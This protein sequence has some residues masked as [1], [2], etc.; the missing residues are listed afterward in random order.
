MKLKKSQLVK[1]IRI[2]IKENLEDQLEFQFGDRPPTPP[3]LVRRSM[4][5]KLCSE[6]GKGRY[7]ETTFFDDMDGVFHCKNCGHEVRAYEMVPQSE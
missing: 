4:R 3:S 1:V 6:C 7:D 5:N 2:L